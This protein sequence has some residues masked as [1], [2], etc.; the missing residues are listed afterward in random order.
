MAGKKNNFIN[1]YDNNYDTICR[2]IQILPYR[3]NS[4]KSN[5][6]CVLEDQ[7][8]T[9]S[10]KHAF[11]KHIADV[12]GIPDVKL[13]L[14]IF[15][16]NARNTLKIA[17]VLSKYQLAE[18]PEA[19]NYLKINGEI[20]DFTRKGSKPEN[21]VEDLVQEIEIGTDQIT[22]FKVNY[23]REF[24]RNYLIQNPQIPYCLEELWNIREE[25]IAALQK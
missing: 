24:I 11:L 9:C 14:G 13:M 23:H 10:T 16:M 25:C 22:D 15:L 2:I 21:F 18:M 3:R 6:N 17:S 7:G 1:I 12:K 20:K 5:I 4:D 8:G 19:H